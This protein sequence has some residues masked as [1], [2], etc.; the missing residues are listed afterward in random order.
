LGVPQTPEETGTGN[1]LFSEWSVV[2][3]GNGNREHVGHGSVW[4]PCEAAGGWIFWIW[5][6]AAYLNLRC[7][8]A[9]DSVFARFSWLIFGV[10]IQPNPWVSQGQESKNCQIC[11]PG[12]NYSTNLYMWVVGETGHGPNW[13]CVV[14]KQFS[15]HPHHVEWACRGVSPSIFN[16]FVQFTGV[17]LVCLFF[18]LV[19]KKFGY[20]AGMQKINWGLKKAAAGGSRR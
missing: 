13:I 15:I 9:S 2:G 12:V 5:N 6:V 1:N 18:R 3:T 7:R 11:N 8:S 20:P 19:G 17:R 14:D 10:V 16:I 4:S